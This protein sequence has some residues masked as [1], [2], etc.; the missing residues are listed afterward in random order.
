M[1]IRPERKE[2]ET[3]WMKAYMDLSGVTESQARNV[4]MYVGCRDEIKSDAFAS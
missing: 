2:N 1:S 4:Y 3:A